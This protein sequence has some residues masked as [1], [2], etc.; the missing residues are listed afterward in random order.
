[1]REALKRTNARVVGV[2]PIVEGL[3]IKGP[4]D[5]ML[6]VLGVEVSAFGVAKFYSDFLDTFIIDT[7]DAGEKSRIEK[8]GLNVKVTN[9]LMKSLEDKVALAKVVLESN[10]VNID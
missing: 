5:K 6:R 3:P 2:S 9:T 8:L 10:N 1:V 4:A 7:K